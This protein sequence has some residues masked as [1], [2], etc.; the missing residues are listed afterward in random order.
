MTIAVGNDF[1]AARPA[2]DGEE[3]S[4]R[5]ALRLTVLFVAVVLVLVWAGLADAHPIN[6]SSAR[7]LRPDGTSS[8]P[9]LR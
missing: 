4:I 5:E 2:P 8:S 9:T 3:R 1:E 6:D 7:T